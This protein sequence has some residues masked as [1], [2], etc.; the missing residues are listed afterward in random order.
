MFQPTGLHVLICR[1]KHICSLPRRCSIC[2]ILIISLGFFAPV[3]GDP[4]S[5]QRGARIEGQAPAEY[6]A[7]QYGQS[8]AVVIGIDEYSKAPRLTYAA[9][10]ANAVASLLQQRGFHVTLLLN[11]HASRRDIYRELFDKLAERVKEQD[12]VLVFFAGHGETRELRGGR[13]IG[14]LLPVDGDPGALSESSI[15]MVAISELADALPAKHVLFVVDSCYGGIAGHRF[16]AIPKA[17]ESYLREITL[18]RGRQLITAGGAKQ[19]ALEGP[20][21]GHSVFTYYL[22]EGLGKGRADLNDDG[23]IPASEL[24]YYLDQRV[25]AAASLQGH[26][27]RPQMWSMGA[28]K[29]EFVFFT[30]SRSTSTAGSMNIPQ[31]SGEH[32]SSLNPKDRS[33]DLHVG[34]DPDKPIEEARIRPPSSSPVSPRALQ[35]TYKLHTTGK[36]GGFRTRDPNPSPYFE[37]YIWVPSH[38]VIEKHLSF[39]PDGR[40]EEVTYVAMEYSE[41]GSAYNDPLKQTPRQLK[42]KLSGTFQVK[43]TAGVLTYSTG[44]KVRFHLPT[45]DETFWPPETIMVKDTQWT[46]AE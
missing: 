27:Q 9:D 30:A 26:T 8:W 43:G 6:I 5:S 38:E 22:L 1:K 31:L 34:S 23:I 7:Q 14:F 24:Y 46:L 39:Y 16:R 33:D 41:P 42:E 35:G 4:G 21:W 12:R 29:G 25:F 40:F 15:S 10:D 2:A 13:E 11:Q 17:T 20:K 44:S 36:L 32:P 45:F 19:E 28:E 18:E 37:P 3:A